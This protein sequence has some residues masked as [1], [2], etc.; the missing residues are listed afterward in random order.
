[1]QPCKAARYLIFYFLLPDLPPPN[2]CETP[3]HILYAA[4]ARLLHVPPMTNTEFWLIVVSLGFMAATHGHGP[5]PLS[6]FSSI[7]FDDLAGD[8]ASPLHVPPQ[9]R[10][11]PDFPSIVHADLLLIVVYKFTKVAS[12]VERSCELCSLTFCS[13]WFGLAWVNHKLHPGQTNACW[14]SPESSPQR[15]NACRLVLRPRRSRSGETRGEC[16]MST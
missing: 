13:M 9:P 14:G 1:M 4:I 12:M 15:E 5:K 16:L 2:G 3:P 10:I 7:S 8:T 6:K 11:I